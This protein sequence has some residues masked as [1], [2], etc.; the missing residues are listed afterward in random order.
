MV[1][2]FLAHS[3]ADKIFARKLKTDLEHKGYKVWLDESEIFIGQSIASRINKGLQNSDYLLLLLSD[4]SVKSDWV[5]KEWTSLLDSDTADSPTILPVIVN[6]CTI[7]PILKGKRYA[8]L[9]GQYYKDGF[10]EIIKAIESLSKETL[11]SYPTTHDQP[12]MESPDLIRLLSDENKALSPTIADIV[13]FA[14]NCKDEPLLKYATV[15]LTGLKLNKYKESN[16]PDWATS[17]L[18]DSYIGTGGSLDMSSPAWLGNTD[19]VWQYIKNSP[20][21]IYKRLLVPDPILWIER[22]AS[23]AKHDTINVSEISS[24]RLLKNGSSTKM[25]PCYFNWDAYIN[26]CVKVRHDLIRLLTAHI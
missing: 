2:I 17:R 1:Q 16:A 11:A 15:Q 5:T 26:I 25:L 22:Q 3:S 12:A 6:K 14:K 9:S 19:R 13:S 21:Y 4:N 7:P 10:C 20:D 8:D 24:S 18:M 23:K